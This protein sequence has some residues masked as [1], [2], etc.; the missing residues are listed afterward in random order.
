[1]RRN[2]LLNISE[3]K[4][5][6]KT[7]RMKHTTLQKIEKILMES[8]ITVNKIINECILSGLENIM[9]NKRWLFSIFLI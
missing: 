8:N 3:P 4:S 7:I 6:L 2:R 9:K 1:M 5:V